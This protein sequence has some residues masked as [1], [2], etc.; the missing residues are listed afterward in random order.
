MQPETIRQLYSG[1]LIPSEWPLP[2][3]LE[4]ASLSA[5]ISEL[6]NSLLNRLSDE[7]KAA[8]GELM[9]A[10]N[11]MTLRYSEQAFIDGYKMATCLLF[12]GLA[13]P[14]RTE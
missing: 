8:L 12:E 10:K 11:L 14:E 5:E 6:L 3:T 1:T 7:D 4:N 2:D 9:S 13:E